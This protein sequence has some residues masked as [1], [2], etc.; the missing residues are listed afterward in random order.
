[1]NKHRRDETPPLK[2]MAK[3][4]GHKKLRVGAAISRKRAS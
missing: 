1:M 4:F 2:V 3:K